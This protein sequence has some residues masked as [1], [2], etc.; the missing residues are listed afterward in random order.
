V[1]CFNGLEFISD[2]FKR[3]VELSGFFSGRLDFT[4]NKSD[5]D[6][7]IQLYEQ[8]PSGEY[9]QLSFY[10]ARASHV[11]D[12]SHRQLLVPQ[13][14]QALDFQCNVVTSRL[15]QT[16]SRLVIVLKI[17]KQPDEQINY[18]TGKDVSDENIADA[19]SLLR[20]KWFSSSFVDVP[21]RGLDH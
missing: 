3:P 14:R 12:L 9:I 1:R 8:L 10:A 19:Q 20:I 6:F 7:N 21:I 2:P 11:R 5:F 4:T 15:L 18:G 13:K 17:I 16:G